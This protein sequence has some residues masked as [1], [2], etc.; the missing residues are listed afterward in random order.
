M[1]VDVLKMRQGNPFGSRPVTGIAAGV[2]WAM[3]ECVVDLSTQV[4]TET[5]GEVGEPVPAMSAES[6]H[7]ARPGMSNGVGRGEADTEIVGVTLAE[8]LIVT[9]G[10]GVIVTVG[11]YVGVGEGVGFVKLEMPHFNSKYRS[12]WRREVTLTSLV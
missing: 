1:V 8:K 5:P 10:L 12:I 9:V 2:P 6:N 7:W 11:L 3:F 4:E